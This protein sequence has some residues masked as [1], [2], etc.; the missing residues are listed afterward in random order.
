MGFPTFELCL[1]DIVLRHPTKEL[2]AIVSMLWGERNLESRVKL[3]YRYLNPNDRVHLNPADLPRLV[4]ILNEGLTDGEKATRGGDALIHY[5]CGRAGLTAYRP[6]GPVPAGELA[7]ALGDILSL[8]RG[9]AGIVP[10][11]PGKDAASL[12]QGAHRAQAALLGI[13]RALGAD[14]GTLA[15]GGRT[16]RRDDD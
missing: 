13:T 5:L 8:A 9:L 16:E 4:E 14:D 7:A 2:S 6:S 10:G 12:R 15:G 1:R 3:M 11:G